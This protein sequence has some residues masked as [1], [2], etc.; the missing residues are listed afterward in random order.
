MREITDLM[1]NSCDIR[2]KLVLTLG[3]KAVLSLPLEDKNTQHQNELY[4][5][6]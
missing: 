5:A 1:T 3:W 2:M 4:E 6:R